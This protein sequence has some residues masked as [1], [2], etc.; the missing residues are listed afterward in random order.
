MSDYYQQAFGRLDPHHDRDVAAKF[1]L[2]VLVMDECFDDLADL[3]TDGHDI[4]ALEGEPGWIIERRDSGPSGDMP[5]YASWP[6]GKN[7]RAYVDPLGFELAYPE[8]FLDTAVFRN[9]VRQLVDAC[10][11]SDPSNAGARKIRGMLSEKGSE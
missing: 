11:L 8:G 2:S 4:G 5:G 10:L 1:A 9:Y 6:E 3:L 7:F